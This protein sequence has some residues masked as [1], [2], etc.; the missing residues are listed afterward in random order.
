MINNTTKQT[1]L[2]RETTNGP[3]Y[4]SQ[5]QD[6]Q[7]YYGIPYAACPRWQPPCDPERWD[8]PLDCS[9]PAR[10]FFQ[11]FDGVPDGEEHQLTLDIYTT[12][13]AEKRPVLLYIHGGNN[14]AGSTEE[15]PGFDLTATD[16]CVFIRVT[17][18][19]GILGF[20]PLPA[21]HTE[22]DSTGNYTLLD[23][24]KALDW[25][26]DNASYFGGD[27][28]N[29]TISGFSAGGRDVMAMLISPLF[30]NCFHKAIAFSGGITVADPESS[31]IQ[32]ARA[33]APL[34][35]Q[36]KKA[37]DLL[38]AGEWLLTA[39]SDVK[40]WL[41]HLDSRRLAPLMSNANIRMSVFPHLFAD[42]VILPSAGFSGKNFNSVPLLLLTGKTEFSMFSLGDPF[43]TTKTG[44]SLS[45]KEQM[46][47]QAFAIRYGSELYRHFNTT[48]SAR[49]LYGN[50]Q[51]PMYLCQINFGST[52]SPVTIPD[53]GSYH[54]VFLPML[55]RE[56][57]VSFFDFSNEE[58]F[59]RMS[60]NFHTY[61]RSF[62]HTGNPNAEDLPDWKIWTPEE[63]EIMFFDADSSKALLSC[64]NE[65][66]TYESILEKIDADISL[67]EELKSLVLANILNG[68]WFSEQLDEYYHH[69]SLWT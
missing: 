17:Y 65:T 63:P 10:P 3:V 50:Y 49:I 5:M 8:A 2:F 61:L 23:L 42:D 51:A 7:V 21:L 33:L 62:L 27:P 35:V 16:S 18:R 69:E 68:R 48:N 25:I 52:E 24:K 13:K 41:Y 12:S 31:A 9:R 58:G 28:E 1:T 6:I 54:G 19:L 47:A 64:R 57:S 36:D 44:S 56:V 55:S 14:Q 32:V 20:N 11:Q 29:I 60:A 45:V 22:K 67:S 40:E 59:Q 53:H 38:K 30:K 37:T 39:G 15:L 34:C 66:L 26:H 43:W 4:G 46:H